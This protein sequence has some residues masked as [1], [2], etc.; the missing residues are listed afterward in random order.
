M[1]ATHRQHVQDNVQFSSKSLESSKTLSVE[2]AKTAIK[3]TGGIKSF[4]SSS[5][6]P[7]GNV[8]KST[9][10]QSWQSKNHG[11]TDNRKGSVLNSLDM[12]LGNKTVTGCCELMTRDRFVVDV[13]YDK[14]LIEVFKMM[15]SKEYDAST[16]K[17][18]F[19]LKD[20]R[21]LMD[22][23]KPLSVDIEPL[24]NAVLRTF[25]AQLN[26]RDVT[27]QIPEHNLNNV[28]SKL[29]NTLMPFQ[30]EGVNFVISRNGR[31]LLADDMGL[32]K[33]MQS[34]CIAC[35][36]RTEWPVLIVV[37]SSVKLTWAEAFKKWV[38]SLDPEQ[39][40]VVNT[41][42]DIATSGLVNIIS[43]DMM[44]RKAEELKTK[45]FQVVIMDESH[46]LKNFKTAR[47]KAAMPLLKT[48]PRVVLL[49]GTPAL[50]RPSELYTQITAI[51]PKLFPLFQ[52]FGVRYC[53]GHQN[54]WGWDFS[55]SSH[56][57]ELQ[58]LLQEKIMIRR[59]KK[60]VLLQLPSKTRQMIVMDPGVV[61]TQSSSLKAAANKMSKAL[62]KK[63]Q[64][65]ALLQYFS[66]TGAAKI[67]A[68]RRYMFDL[69]DGDHKF[70]MFAHH[71]SL[72]DALCTALTEKKYNFI[73][74][75]GST[76]SDQ[77]KVLCDQFQDDVDCKVAILSITAA[78]TGI[79][80][81]SAC[82]VVFAELFWN[83]GV[84]VQAEDR[85]Y[86]IGQKNSV[87]IQYLVA[88]ETADDF[89]WPLVQEKL[90]VLSKAGLTKDD[91]S[92]ADTKRFK[93]VENA[94]TGAPK[95]KF[96]KKKK[97]VA[98]IAAHLATIT[99]PLL[100]L[101]FITEHQK[102]DESVEERY[103]CEMC[104]AK[105]DP[106]TL[107]PHLLGIKHRIG[108]MKQHDKTLLEEILK[109]EANLKKSEQ[110]V[111]ILE[112]AKKIESEIGR[113]EV[114]VKVELNPF[115]N[116]T[117]TQQPAKRQLDNQQ[118][119]GYNKAQ[120]VGGGRGGRGGYSGGRGGR[121][122][123]GGTGGTGGGYNNYGQGGNR[124]RG[125]KQDYNGG[126]SS[127][128]GGSYNTNY[129]TNT[130]REDYNN[131]NKGNEDRWSAGNVNRGSSFDSFYDDKTRGSG[132]NDTDRFGYGGSGSVG[133]G[134]SGSVGFGGASRYSASGTGFS[135]GFS[136]GDSREAPSMSNLLKDLSKCVVRNEEDAAIAL[137]VSNA[138]TQ[139]LL[140]YRTQGMTN[141]Y[142]GS[143]DGS[144]LGMMGHQSSSLL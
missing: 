71:Q 8:K 129:S 127:Y 118:Q 24:P 97:K 34:I 74:I 20:Y 36:Y 56:M 117:V 119:T 80:L 26:G 133:F 91:F 131:L 106:R 87:N 132:F 100:G 101:E 124:G 123:Y 16:K 83:P 85:V 44:S 134:G 111:K 14:Q 11:N 50:S 116:P 42:K 141:E 72:L 144:G 54:N 28:D 104:S 3:F 53:D 78:S 68:I 9:S 58:V 39:I 4:Y 115:Y 121:G 84:L 30:K 99:E 15:E 55:G 10:H 135:A 22:A 126:Q 65:G 21:N 25:H 130:F 102:E 112:I 67:P 31:A 136:G 70:L 38:P 59:L 43:Y 108:F 27:R 139:A 47:T 107:V 113:K 88:R 77:R 142:G 29:V 61:K 18:N 125:Q 93:N 89:I 79:T 82:L 23:I 90:D 63:E 105:C 32:G 60:N 37:P 46:S 13:A 41:K 6:K 81:H 137:Q 92:Q 75:D 57:T 86:R 76:T 19:A 48:A 64:R 12:Y 120:R 33:T 143:S 140:N 94:K 95:V 62:S 1:T 138:L 98:K 7:N 110:N 2:S 5:N 96:V 109:P 49:S 114:Q 103:V 69:L 17:W 40:N 45:R 35:Y 66:E 128:L 73:R 51:D 122:A 52:D